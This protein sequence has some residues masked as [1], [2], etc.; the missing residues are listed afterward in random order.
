MRHTLNTTLVLK[1]FLAEQDQEIFG[2]SITETTA[3]KS[4]TLY[5]ILAR[6]ENNGLLSSRWEE[7]DASELGRPRRRL[8]KITALGVHNARI[9][10]ARLGVIAD[11]EQETTGGALNA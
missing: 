8:Y 9:E 5:P 2:A 1:V 4:G 10:L 6:L 7:S 11:G 3:L